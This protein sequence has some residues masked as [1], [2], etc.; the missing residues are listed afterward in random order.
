[1]DHHIFWPTESLHKLKIGALFELFDLVLL[2][3]KLIKK[4][5]HEVGDQVDNLFFGT[6]RLCRPRSAILLKNLLLLQLILRQALLRCA[7]L[8]QLGRTLSLWGI[9]VS[10]ARLRG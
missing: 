6:F 8:R 1:M 4:L 5:N 10:R 2:Q 7:M 9:A 3:S